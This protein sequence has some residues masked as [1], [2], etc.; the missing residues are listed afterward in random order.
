MSVT[1]GMCSS[2]WPDRGEWTTELDVTHE[3]Y[4]RFQGF[5]DTDPS[6]PT[7]EH[8]EVLQEIRLTPKR[9]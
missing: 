7:G 8:E 9:R 5:V 1:I 4:E 3:D 2:D 6:A